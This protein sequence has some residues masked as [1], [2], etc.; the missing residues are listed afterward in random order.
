MPERITQLDHARTTAYRS[1][2]L[3]YDRCQLCN[4][5]YQ[6]IQGIKLEGSWQALDEAVKLELQ[7]VSNTIEQ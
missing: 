4:R 7:E 5:E 1:L 2:K 6:C 3:H